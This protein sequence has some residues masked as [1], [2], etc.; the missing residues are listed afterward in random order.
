[1]SATAFPVYVINLDRSPERLAAVEASAAR[2]AIAFTRI[3]AVDGRTLTIAGHP[4]VDVARFET[5]NGRSLVAGEVGC[6]LSHVKALEAF[7]A[8]GREIGLICEDDVDFT[9]E[10][11]AFMGRLAGA[12]DWDVVKLFNFR[13]R[14]FVP[15][16]RLSDEW[17]LGRCLHGPSGSSASYAVTRNGARRL[18]DNLL[19]MIVPYDVALERGW[20]G[21]HRFYTTSRPVIG[22]QP[23]ETSTIVGQG[24]LIK[25]PFY[26]R[27][28]TLA[29]RASEYV[30]R[31]AFAMRGASARA[32]R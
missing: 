18:I 24:G 1:M 29:F 15:H 19:P 13:Y 6:Y 26:R 22:L 9:S 7:L 31:M 20:K 30:R 17:T 32:R 4:G 11:P 3:A 16:H 25:Y 27:S 8:D 12:S 2:H 21:D 28:G 23:V 10:T 5:V 14:G